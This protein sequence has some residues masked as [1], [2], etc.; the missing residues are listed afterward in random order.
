[1][2]ETFLAYVALCAVWQTVTENKS[3]PESIRNRL[4]MPRVVAATIGYPRLYQGWGMFAP[5]PITDDGAIAVDARTI[6]GRRVDPFTGEPPL[7]DLTHAE[8][9]GLGQI[10]QDYFNRIR[11][12]ANAKFRGNLEGYLRGYHL[13]TGR[14]EDELVAIDVYWVRTQ[15][16]VPCRMPHLFLHVAWKG[17][18]PV[19]SDVRHVPRECPKPEQSRMY[20]NE[21]IALSTWRK[22]GYRPPPGQPP[23]PPQPPLGHGDTKQPDPEPEGAGR[24]IRIPIFF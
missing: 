3:I 23:L 22:P 1:M 5:N 17:A 6:D 12:D 24:D 8:G 19:F 10:P 15:V 16:P 7:L 9:L 13:R 20:G 2:R 18:K 4:T 21:T 14:P 11:L